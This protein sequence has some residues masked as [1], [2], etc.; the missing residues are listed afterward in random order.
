MTTTHR[1]RDLDDAIRLIR[2][3]RLGEHFGE[4]LHPF[5]QKKYVECWQAAQVNDPEQD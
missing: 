5:A 1:P 2:V 4:Q 3:N